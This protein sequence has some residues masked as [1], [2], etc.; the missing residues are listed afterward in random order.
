[1]VQD[2]RPKQVAVDRSLVPDWASSSD[3]TFREL[4]RSEGSW[5][6]KLL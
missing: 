2:K 4:M 1:M 5:N 6:N 3:E